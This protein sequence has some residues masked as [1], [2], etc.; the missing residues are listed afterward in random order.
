LYIDTTGNLKRSYL[1]DR[2]YSAL[3]KYI[4]Q[5]YIGA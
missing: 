2:S 5:I 1:D 3:N 4:E